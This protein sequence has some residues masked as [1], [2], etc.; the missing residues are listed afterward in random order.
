M[1][2][3][4][5]PLA[6]DWYGPEIA[7][8]GVGDPDGVRVRY[9]AQRDGPRDA[10]PAVAAAFAPAAFQPPVQG[11][12]E[13]SVFVHRAES[14]LRSS[15]ASIPRRRLLGHV[16]SRVYLHHERVPGPRDAS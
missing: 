15:H 4:V 10:A 6:S 1:P 11:Q 14:A 8:E 7:A 2:D 13:R 16:P 12:R 5:Y 3:E 9:L